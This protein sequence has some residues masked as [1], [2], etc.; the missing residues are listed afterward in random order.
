VIINDDDRTTAYFTF[1]S[2]MR[3]TLH[4][5][6]IYGPK[7][8][9]I[10]DQDKETLVKLRGAM[11]KSYAE[12]FVPPVMMAGQNF[13]N[14]TTNL[15]TFLARD[16]QMKAGMKCLI[17]SFYRSIV[18]DAPLPIPYR[19]ILLTATIMESIFS[20]LG[21]QRAQGQAQGVRSSLRT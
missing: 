20:E 11:Y 9:L 5:F 13:G 8:G 16:F 21:E 7:N 6:R 2:Q 4:E 18:E 10:L 3:P 15:K 17:E 12:K 19:E 14:L 1:S